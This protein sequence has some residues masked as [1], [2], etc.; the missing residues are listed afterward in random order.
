MSLDGSLLR[1]PQK[2]E[3]GHSSEAVQDFQQVLGGIWGQVLKKWVGPFISFS[4]HCSSAQQ[5]PSTEGFEAC[6][7]DFLR[8]STSLL[9]SRHAASPHPHP[10]APPCPAAPVSGTLNP[11]GPRTTLEPPGW[12]AFLSKKKNRKWFHQLDPPYCYTGRRGSGTALPASELCSHDN[13]QVGVGGGHQHRTNDQ[14]GRRH[15]MTRPPFPKLNNCLLLKK[16]QTTN[17]IQEVRKE[18]K[19]EDEKEDQ[20]RLRH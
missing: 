13:T 16:K 14:T 8:S 2:Q 15:H 11:L 5:E 7:S 18:K 6:T 17:L 9:A 1:S 10:T 19:E 12:V 20:P 3:R 4:G